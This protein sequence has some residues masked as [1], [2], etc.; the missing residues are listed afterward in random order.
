L[1]QLP[2][3]FT[4]RAFVCLIASLINID[5]RAPAILSGVAVY[6]TGLLLQT[7]L[8]LRCSVLESAGDRWKRWLISG[9]GLNC[10]REVRQFQR[11][12]LLPGQAGEL[13]TGLTLQQS[14]FCLL[15]GISNS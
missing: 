12:L 9:S 6:L 5:I 8:R 15:A 2:G 7:G 10:F 14:A 1:L 11:D 13:Q 4:G 3:L